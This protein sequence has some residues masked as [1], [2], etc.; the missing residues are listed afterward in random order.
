VF[1]DDV[2]TTFAQGGRA[3]STYGIDPSTGA[4]VVVRPD[5]YIGMVAA[6]EN[7]SEVNEYFS[8]FMKPLPQY[9]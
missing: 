4:I 7:V 6:F 8:S 1:I 9:L 2:N 3:Y 5:G